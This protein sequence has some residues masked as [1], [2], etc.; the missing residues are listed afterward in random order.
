MC[1]ILIKNGAKEEKQK[2][3]L[4][5]LEIKR[6]ARGQKERRRVEE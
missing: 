6:R 3:K 1:N 5:T 4:K 2:K